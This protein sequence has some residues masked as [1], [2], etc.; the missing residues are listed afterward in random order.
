MNNY[1]TSDEAWEAGQQWIKNSSTW[2]KMEHLKESCTEYFF[3]DCTLL[4][5]MARWMS[6]EEFTKFFKHLCS[7]WEIKTPQEIDY[8]MNS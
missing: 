8:E 2:E 1:K 7:N 5:E 3:K 4:G 6:Q